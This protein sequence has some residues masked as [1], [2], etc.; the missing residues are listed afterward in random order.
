MKKYKKIAFNKNEI[1]VAEIIIIDDCIYVSDW[2]DQHSK[3]SNLYFKIFHH[4]N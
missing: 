1:F 3:Y 4:K 2:N